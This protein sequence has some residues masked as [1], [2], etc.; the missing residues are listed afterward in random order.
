VVRLEF[1][2]DQIDHIYHTVQ[3]LVKEYINQNTKVMFDEIRKSTV[4]A[5][6]KAKLLLNPNA[7]STATNGNGNG[8]NNNA[9]TSLPIMND[10]SEA[11][12]ATSTTTQM[13]RLEELAEFCPQLTIQ[14]RLIG[15]AVSFSLGCT[16]F[17]NKHMYI[18]LLMYI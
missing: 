15:F 14:Q 1:D 2:I 10:D 17:L 11:S 4:G 13:D 16:Y 5:L 8:S 9:A 3:T 6:D 18:F 12:Q 7:T